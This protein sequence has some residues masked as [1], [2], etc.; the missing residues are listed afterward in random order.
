MTAEARGLERT[1]I[2][3]AL[4]LMYF[5]MYQP[6]AATVLKDFIRRMTPEERTIFA[7]SQNVLVREREISQMFV[8]GMVGRNFAPAL[9]FFLGRYYE[10]LEEMYKLTG[11]KDKPEDPAHVRNEFAED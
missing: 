3:N 6:R 11:E 2:I 5:W 1:I 4:D 7:R 10:Y 9:A 8:D